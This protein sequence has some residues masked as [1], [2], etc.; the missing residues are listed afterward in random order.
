MAGDRSVVEFAKKW[1][2]AV[3]RFELETGP[4]MPRAQC[5]PCSRQERLYGNCRTR[6]DLSCCSTIQVAALR[7]AGSLLDTCTR[8]LCGLRCPPQNAAR[9]CSIAKSSYVSPAS[10]VAGRGS[11]RLGS[12]DWRHYLVASSCKSNQVDTISISPASHE[13]VWR[14][15]TPKI[16]GAAPCLEPVD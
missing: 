14:S 7:Q 13:F 9:G 10:A 11:Y 2:G 5:A 16:C 4:R 6:E 1:P 8:S 3:V 12:C 15:R